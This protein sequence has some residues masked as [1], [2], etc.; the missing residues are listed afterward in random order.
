M[1]VRRMTESHTESPIHLSLTRRQLVAMSLAGAGQVLLGSTRAAA[2]A[3]MLM[4]IASDAV[5]QERAFDFALLATC[6]IP[7]CRKSNISA[8]S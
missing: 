3:F 4:A 8:Y 2:V 6:P 1:Q 5:A 7:R